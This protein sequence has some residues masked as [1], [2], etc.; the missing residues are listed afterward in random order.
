MFALSAFFASLS[1][2]A[3][4]VNSLADTTDAV[5]HGIRERLQLDAPEPVNRLLDVETE[6]NGRGRKG[7]K[8]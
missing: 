4:S 2:L 8:S 7:A 5:N 6:T 3:A 1:R